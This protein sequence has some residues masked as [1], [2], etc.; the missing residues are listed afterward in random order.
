MQPVPAAKY[1][2]NT[3]MEN[4]MKSSGGSASRMPRMLEVGAFVAALCAS[5]EPVNAADAKDYPTRPMRLVVP[6]PPGG[7]NDILGRF[8]AL[9]LTD[10][11]GE[12]MVVDNRPGADGIIGSGIVARAQPDGYTLLVASTSYTMNPAIHSVP[13]DPMKSLIPVSLF[14]SGPSVLVVHPSFQA[15]SVSELIAAA[16]AR[17]GKISY[18]SS[19]VGGFNHFGGELFKQMAGVDIVHVPY[20]GG[21]PAMTDLMAGRVEVQFNT[22]LPLIAH[23]RAGKMRALGVGTSK[24]SSVLPDVPTIAETLPGYE[25]IIWW[26]ILAPAGTPGTIVTRLNR[27]IGSILQEPGTRKRFA[28]EA[29][30]TIVAPPEVFGKLLVTEIAKWARIAK[31]ANIRAHN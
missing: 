4:A 21:L 23:I 28:N 27:E 29:S 1:S 15:N 2:S 3:R 26:G 14:G 22:L 25:S 5:I 17:P 9:K 16:K 24:R 18:A 30:E 20:K 13:F 7:A 19:G 10:R 31:Q 8:F 11:L 12:S 6:F